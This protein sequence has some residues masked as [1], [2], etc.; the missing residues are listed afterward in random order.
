MIDTANDKWLE[1]F[2]H[3]LKYERNLSPK[4]IENYARQ[5]VAV[6]E[7]ATIEEWSQLD[8]NEVK[9]VLSIARKKE[10]S[11]RSI[12]TRLSALRTFCHFLIHSI[13]FGI[14]SCSTK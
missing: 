9:R 12:S 5:L 3:H 8:T 13:S 6:S 1:K 11:P 10:L 4:T 2:T 7:T 14:V